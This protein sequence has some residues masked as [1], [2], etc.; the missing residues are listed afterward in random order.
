MSLRVCI[1][2]IHSLQSQHMYDMQMVFLRS[3]AGTDC[4]VTTQNGPQILSMARFSRFLFFYRR[5]N[6]KSVKTAG[7]FSSILKYLVRPFL[8][9]PVNLNYF[10]FEVVVQQFFANSPRCKQKGLLFFQW[11]SVSFRL[12]CKFWRPTVISMK[13]KAELFVSIRLSKNNH[14]RFY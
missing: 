3:I 6:L 9:N 8:K 7:S 4:T 12:L 11:K 13:F 1:S 14:R 5:D 2:S 10:A